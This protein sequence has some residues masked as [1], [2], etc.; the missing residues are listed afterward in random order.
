MTGATG[1]VGRH[2]IRHQG[3]VRAPYP[4][5]AT[6]PVH[7]AG[8]AAIAFRGGHAV[9]RCSLTGPS[10]R[11]FARWADERTDDFR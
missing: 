3:A 10:V 7:E 2:L 11:S 4:G 5:A 6:A 9:R 1:P 8:L